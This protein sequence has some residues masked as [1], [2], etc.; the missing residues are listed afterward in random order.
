H[1]H[2]MQYNAGGGRTGRFD[3]ALVRNC[4]RLGAENKEFFLSMQ[5]FRLLYNFT[6][7]SLLVGGAQKTFIQDSAI[8]LMDRWNGNDVASKFRGEVIPQNKALP[9]TGEVLWFIQP[10]LA[11]AD[12]HFKIDVKKFPGSARAWMNGSNGT[13]EVDDSYAKSA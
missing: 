12:A 13:G 11:Q 3:M 2:W 8:S 6:P 5:Y 7:Q 9:H 1:K 10:A 4:D